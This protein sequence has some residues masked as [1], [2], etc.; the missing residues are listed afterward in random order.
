M[1]T[2][3]YCMTFL[4]IKKSPFVI[5]LPYWCAFVYRGA[6]PHDPT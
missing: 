5:D 4:A 1:I 2:E 6:C 3:L